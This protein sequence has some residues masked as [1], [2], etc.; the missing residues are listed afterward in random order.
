MTSA[1]TAANEPVKVTVAMQRGSHR[2]ASDVAKE[3]IQN[4][5]IASKDTQ[6]FDGFFHT[7]VTP[8]KLDDIAAIDPIREISNFLEEEDLLNIS[9]TIINLP[10]TVMEINAGGDVGLAD[11]RG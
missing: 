1:I 11:C 5:T 6:M 4:G 2:S 10:D 3:L 8:D 7:V 9:R